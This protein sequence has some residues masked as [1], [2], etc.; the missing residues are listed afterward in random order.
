MDG[1][2]PAADCA[3]IK[4]FSLRNG[5]KVFEAIKDYQMPFNIITKTCI[6]QLEQ[7]WFRFN[8]EVNYKFNRYASPPLGYCQLAWTWEEGA[9]TWLNT[10]IVVERA[11]YD[12]ILGISGS[13]RHRTSSGGAFPTGIAP[14][15]RG[16]PSNPA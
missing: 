16:S 2:T 13:Q 1:A 12:V 5:R 4:I 8:G 9:S 10:F 11:T 14:P 7:P 6:D 3:N 15:S